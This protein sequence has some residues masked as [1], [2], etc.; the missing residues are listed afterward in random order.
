M[1]RFCRD[2]AP[3]GL[4]LTEILVALA[5]LGI[6][7]VGMTSLAIGVLN[8]NAKSR[9]MATAAYLAHDRLETI[10]N[11]AYANITTNNNPT[12]D[13]GAIR[14]GT[15]SVTFS[16]FRRAV[17]IQDDTPIT[18]MKRVVVTVSWQG[19]S[20]REEMLVGQ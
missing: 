9:A 10:R 13:Y 7:S 17:T 11:T 19:G 15:P 6:I 18:G 2:L 4:T 1:C 8:G 3:K 20:V 12:E 14:V 16:D 5:V